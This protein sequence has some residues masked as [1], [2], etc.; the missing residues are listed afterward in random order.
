MLINYN[1]FYFGVNTDG[2]HFN[3]VATACHYSDQYVCLGGSHQ[4]YP[5]LACG[6]WCGQYQQSIRFNGAEHVISHH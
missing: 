5:Q 6:I 1:I 3:T 4:C 2:H